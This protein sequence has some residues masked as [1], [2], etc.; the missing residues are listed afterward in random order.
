[1]SSATQDPAS[2]R[3]PAGHIFHMDG[4]VLRSVSPS[5]AED[6]RFIR[7]SGL[8]T[9]LSDKGMLIGARE[10]D[11][12]LLDGVDAAHVLEH[13]RIPFLSFP[14]E[15]GF[16]AL[17]SAALLTLDVH[18]EALAGGATL[19]DASAYNIQFV[20]PRPVF[21]DVL[22]LRRYKDGEY[23]RAQRQFSEHFLNPLLLHAATGVSHNAWFRG[24]L[25]GIPIGA[26][27]ALLPLRWKWRWTVLSNVVL[28][29]AMH[30]RLTE[31]KDFDASTL[32]SRQLPKAALVGLLTQLRSFIAKLSPKSRGGEWADYTEWHTYSDTALAMKKEAVA[33]FVAETKPR[34]LWD[35]GCNTGVFSE[36]ALGAGA[37]RIIGFDADSDAVDF[38]FRRASASALEFLPLLMD[39]ANPSPDQGWRQRERPGLSGRSRPDALIALAFLH[40]MVIGKNIP[41]GDAI[42]WLVSLAP[43]GLVEF[44]P[45]NDPTVTTM[46]SLRTG[47]DFSDYDEAHF[48]RHLEKLARIVRREPIMGSDRVL[49]HYVRE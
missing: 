3:D 48:V 39:A 8:L 46:L 13:P 24:A 27:A 14:Y 19:V 45:R 12:G 44:V 32:K 2:Y 34:M 25:E 17:K 37:A 47:V 5:G 40:H 22:S 21:I 28:P 33:N 7:D 30:K 29:H 18:L 20:G 6:Y 49:Y 1:M 4:R 35:M 41:L 16:E 9:R 38:A 15:W 26:A 11:V 42:S 23:W 36:V 43:A 10:V 31:K